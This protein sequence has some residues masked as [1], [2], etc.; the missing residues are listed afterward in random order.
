MGQKLFFILAFMLCAGY[1]QSQATFGVK[2]GL[3]FA[4]W[5]VVDA[6]DSDKSDTRTGILLGINAEMPVTD[7]VTIQTELLYGMFGG[8]FNDFWDEE[9]YKVNYLLVP[10]LGKYNFSNGISVMAGP[11]LGYLVSAKWDIDGEKE[12]FRD[13]MKKTDVFLVLGGEYNLRNGLS[14]GLRIQHGLT[15]VEDGAS[16][17]IYNRSVALTANYRLKGTLKEIMNGIF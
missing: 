4:K 1:G 6:S 2:G 11:Q 16:A 13:Q 7:M 8:S 9:D 15:N 17:E 14:F 5:K 12:N 3:N 10:V